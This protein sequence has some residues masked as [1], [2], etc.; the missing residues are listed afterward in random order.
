MPTLAWWRVLTMAWKV[1]EGGSSP[2]IEG[3]GRREE[4][5]AKESLLE[6]RGFFKASSQPKLLARSVGLG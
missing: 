1:L 5:W 2:Q 4:A 6:S 3:A